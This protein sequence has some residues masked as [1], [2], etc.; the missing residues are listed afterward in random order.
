MRKII[1]LAALVVALGTLSGCEA[2]MTYEREIA[3]LQGGGN[4]IPLEGYPHCERPGPINGHSRST[5]N[6]G[7]LDR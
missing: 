1:L 4:W 2:Q 3:C 6:G 5:L 7:G